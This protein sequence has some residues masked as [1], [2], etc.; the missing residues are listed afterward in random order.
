MIPLI[1]REVITRHQWLTASEFVDIAAVAEMTPGPIA[2]NVATFV[3]YRL[4]GVAGAAVATVAV[5]S[6]AAVLVLF[7]TW[8]LVQ[9]RYRVTFAHVLGSIRPATVALVAAA[10]LWVGRE[11]LVDF[12]SWVIFIAALAGLLSRRVS[13]LATLAVA[14]LAGMVVFG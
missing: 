12:P 8:A 9:S 13:P 7:L 5:V 3:G 14:T 1:E 10:A 6:P 11:T 4:A 2:V